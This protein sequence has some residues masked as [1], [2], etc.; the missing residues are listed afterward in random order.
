MS[1]W[2]LCAISTPKK[3]YPQVPFTDRPTSVIGTGYTPE[4]IDQNPAYYELMNQVRAR[5]QTFAF[6]SVIES[7]NGPSNSFH[8]VLGSYTSS[9]LWKTR[10]RSDTSL[11][12]SQSIVEFSRLF[13]FQQFHPTLDLY[14][15]ERVTSSLQVNFHA[16]PLPDVAAHMVD[17]AHRRYGLQAFDQVLRPTHFGEER[18]DSTIATKQLFVALIRV[19]HERSNMNLGQG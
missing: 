17:R 9:T 15:A 8:T 3:L 2:T 1:L 13:L 12:V 5:V 7:E 18:C 19:D 14:C 6:D 10:P 4:G 16:A 11:R